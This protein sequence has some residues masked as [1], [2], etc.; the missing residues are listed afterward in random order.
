MVRMGNFRVRSPSNAP[1]NKNTL[2][3]CWRRIFLKAYLT[4]EQTSES[5]IASNKNFTMV[6][7]FEK[8]DHII[9]ISG[10]ITHTHTHTHR[11]H[12]FWVFP[13]LFHFV[14][15][16]NYVQ[17]CQHSFFIFPIFWIL[18]CEYVEFMCIFGVFSMH[19]VLRSELF[20]S[21]IVLCVWA[22]V[23]CNQRHMKR[24]TKSLYEIKQRK[25]HI[26]ITGTEMII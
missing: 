14:L 3:F 19:F 8:L 2:F 22:A 5:P 6:N 15:E 9:N 17:C 21:C 10:T 1:S 7:A 24:N 12:S 13:L 11:Q 26:W 23:Q 4:S 25:S 16:R 20:F 18:L